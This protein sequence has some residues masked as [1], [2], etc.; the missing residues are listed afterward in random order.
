MKELDDKRVEQEVQVFGKKLWKK[1][2]GEVP[3]MFNRNYWNGK[4][5]DWVMNDEDFKIDLFRFVDVLP[6]LKTSKQITQHIEEYLN[7]EGRELPGIFKV[8]V[9][10]ATFGITSGIT[11][12]LIKSKLTGLAENFI[13][14]ENPKKAIQTL[15]KLEQQGFD[16]TCDLLG[17]ATTSEKEAEDY[18]Q[19]YL[20][21]M[22]ALKREFP[23]S[24]I[25]L[26]ITAFDSQI[27]NVD[28]IGSVER[29]L[30]R[31]LPLVLEAKKNN[32]FVNLD[33]EQWEFH[34]ITYNVFEELLFHKELQDWPQLGIVIQAYLTSS[35]RDLDRLL[36]LANRRQTPFTVRIVKGAYWD[37]EVVHAKQ[38]GFDCPVF[39]K[40]ED[41]DLRFEKLSRRLLEN[42][43]SIKTAL[44]S[45]N[46]R[47]LSYALAVADLLGVP[48]NE[49]EVQQLFGMA[50]PCWKA[51]QTMGYSI[52]LYTP[53]GELL[54]GMAYLVR[55]LLENTSNSGFLRLSYREGKSMDE[56]LENPL[57]LT[58]VTRS[59]TKNENKDSFSNFPGADFSDPSVYDHFV[60]ATGIVEI[61]LPVEVP[62][63]INGKETNTY[64]PKIRFSPN[65]KNRIISK[66]TFASLKDTDKAVESSMKAWPDWREKS[67]TDRAKVLLRLSDL[68]IEKRYELATLQ[69]FESGKPWKEAD[70][71][72]TE[73]IDFCRYYAFQAKLELSPKKNGITPGE[74][75]ITIFEGRGPTVIIPPWNFPFAIL[76]GMT[77]AALVAGNPVLIKPSSNATASAYRFFSL[78]LQAGCP[79]EIAH[80]LPGSGEEI[81]DKLVTHPLVA[82]IAFTGS[83]KVGL[84]IIE[85]AGKTVLGQP[86]VKR[87]ICEMGGKNAI[88]VDDDADLDAAIAGIIYSAFSYAGQKCSACSRVII[89]KTI[90]EP[91]KERL[92]EAVKSIII[93]PADSPR[94]RL[95]P[96]IDDIA[97]ERLMKIIDGAAASGAKKLYQGVDV[98][99]GYY[100]PPTIF[101]V[102]HGNHDLM[103]KEL[104]GPILTL[105]KVSSFEEALNVALSTE[106]ALTG[107]VYTRLPSHIEMAKKRF[108]VGN[109]YINRGC[110]GALVGRQPFGG[111]AMSGVGTKAGGPGYLQ[112]FVDPR[113]WSENM[114]RRG[115]SP[116]FH[117]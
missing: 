75:N 112:H 51:L 26:K 87:V 101:E 34:H 19:R 40:K 68:I 62:V 92:I 61:R 79:K 54:P 91:F 95:G 5:L 32:I 84:S 23:V 82:Q 73:A 104:F 53:I 97:Y 20:E 25:S 58:K 36:D 1:I 21:L 71:D 99:G 39:L 57:N 94:C 35:E 65:R 52:R 3:G 110:T 70:A 11:T 76:C 85:K 50:E 15:K 66:T 9:K 7:S 89:L 56:L 38:N 18:S 116:D 10:L 109:L 114:M 86:Q 30:T 117:L 43:K 46:L 37:Y 100:I 64:N 107:G 17:E 13:V 45:H 49:M 6:T 72:I 98:I 24:N 55:R 115:F 96:V 103:Q 29:I 93:A 31:V 106:F 22:R 77:T 81:G 108:R 60:S 83:Q 105:M 33:L 42:H 14:G 48:K 59:K 4:L 41:T 90:F 69:S 111:F 44:A 63:V 8:G 67:V 74:E 102:E 88:I 12:K 78:L 2:E 16:F 80:F 47:S 27:N 113:S 28:P